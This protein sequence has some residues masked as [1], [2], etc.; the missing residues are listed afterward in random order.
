[1]SLTR[2][3]VLLFTLSLFSTTGL[4]QEENPKPFNPSLY[5]EK[6][7]LPPGIRYINHGKVDTIDS[8]TIVVDDSSARITKV[9]QFIYE[10]GNQT[11]IHAIYRGKKVDV[12]VGQNYEAVYVV[13]K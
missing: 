1:M 8:E 13:L 7:T 2:I 6:T 5:S 10:D 12:Y 3:A 11:S 9:T 4:A